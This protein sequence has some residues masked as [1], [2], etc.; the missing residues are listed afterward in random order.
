VLDA[1]EVVAS[2]ATSDLTDDSS[3]R[4]LLAV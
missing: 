2:G 1:G 3:V 4:R